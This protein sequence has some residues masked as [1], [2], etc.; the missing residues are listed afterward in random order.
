MRTSTLLGLALL[1]PL[2]VACNLKTF[3]GDDGHREKKGDAG[4]ATD[5]E[6]HASYFATRGELCDTYL[7]LADVG[8]DG[9]AKLTLTIG[10]CGDPVGSVAGTAWKAIAAAATV[11][12]VDLNGRSAHAVVSS[13]GHVSLVTED[14][15]AKEL[16]TVDEAKAYQTISLASGVSAALLVNGVP[17]DLSKHDKDSAGMSVSV[18]AD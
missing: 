10:V 15:D 18:T 2:A 6:T 11:D 1:A 4:G 8:A 13:S 9:A 16:G 17:F 5:G 14:G 12:S 3:N 7:S